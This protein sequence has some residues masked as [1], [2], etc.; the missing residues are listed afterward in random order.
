MT[1]LNLYSGFCSSKYYQIVKLKKIYIGRYNF[2]LIFYVGDFEFTKLKYKI[3]FVLHFLNFNIK[4][5]F[6][7][8]NKLIEKIIL[9]SR[10]N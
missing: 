8:R 6:I 10:I 1:W 2:E 9:Y 3:Y 5:N 4:F 7:F